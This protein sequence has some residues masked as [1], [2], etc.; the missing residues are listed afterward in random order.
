MIDSFNYPTVN[1]TNMSVIRT[2]GVATQQAQLNEDHSTL[3]DHDY[4]N[5]VN[6]IVDMV[7]NF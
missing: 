2:S 5:C 6:E 3:C 1:Y 7:N 4:E